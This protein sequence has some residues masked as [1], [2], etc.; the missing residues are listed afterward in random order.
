MKKKASSC[1]HW[2][3]WITERNVS[4]FPPYRYVSNLLV[5]HHFV[6]TNGN[7]F[8]MYLLHKAP[9]VKNCV[10]L[11]SY[12]YICNIYRAP[13]VKIL[14]IEENTNKNKN[15]FLRGAYYY[16]LENSNQIRTLIDFVFV[17][18]RICTNSRRSTLI[19]FQIQASH[20]ISSTI[21]TQSKILG[22]F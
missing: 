20:K 13:Q 2:K 22:A 18:L 11:D 16:R 3:Y 19:C 6:N 1:Y 14:S 9:L 4:N 21:F 10:N 15:V 12:T 7:K 5:L 8:Y 17:V